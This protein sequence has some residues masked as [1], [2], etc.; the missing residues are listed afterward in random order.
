MTIVG[1][2]SEQ[3]HNGHAA[4]CDSRKSQIIEHIDVLL[5]VQL[6]AT[7]QRRILVPSEECAIKISPMED[8]NLSEDNSN[9]KLN[10]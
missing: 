1:I 9:K 4:K 2:H 5:S 8:P 6:R 7:L 3:S 10:G